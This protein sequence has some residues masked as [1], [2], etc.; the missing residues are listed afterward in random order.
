VFQQIG[1]A[2]VNVVLVLLM[3]AWSTRGVSPLWPAAVFAVA[4]AGISFGTGGTP[5][6]AVGT[7]VA[8]FILGGLYFWVLQRL[9]GRAWW[10]VVL[11]IGAL[12]FAL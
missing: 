11:V 4:R 1:T 2:A 8:A 7:G 12:L 5:L 9:Q 3:A 6:T 10:W